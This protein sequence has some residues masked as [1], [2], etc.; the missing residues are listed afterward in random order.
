M[1]SARRRTAGF[2]LVEVVLAVGVLGL[3]V[4][5]LL[6]VA[7]PLLRQMAEDRAGDEVE[8]VA[9]ALARWAGSEAQMGFDP[10]AEELRGGVVELFGYELTDGPGELSGLEA[11]WRVSREGRFEELRGPATPALAVRG[12]RS[13]LLRLEAMA[14]A[15]PSSSHVPVRVRLWKHGAPEPG[16]SATAWRD[17]FNG[18][19][20]DREVYFVLRR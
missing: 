18:L 7:G 4:I 15:V 12:A 17:R 6:G 3:A 19:A 20:P 1:S 11:G 8:A 5:A 16:T 2:S 14:E 9:E 10:L 13:Y